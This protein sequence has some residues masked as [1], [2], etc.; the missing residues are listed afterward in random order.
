VPEFLYAREESSLRRALLAPLVLLEGPYR[1]GAWLHRLSY[2]RFPRRRVRLPAGVIA[3]GNL[4]VGGSGKTPLVAWLAA[5][6]RDRGRKVAI[7]SRGVGGQRSQ[8]VN[9]VSDGERVLLGPADVGD[10]PVLLAGLVPGVPVLAGRNRAALGYRAAALFGAEAV[11]LDD[12][13]Q[14]HRLERDVDLVCIDAELGLGNGHVLP[15]GPLRESPRG[16]KR[17]DA[18]IFTR[19]PEGF[20]L[21]AAAAKLPHAGDKPSFAASITP[22]Q[23]RMLTGEVRGLDTLQ[24][25][26]VGLL[27]AIA[28]PDRLRQTLA[29]LGAVLR[30][31]RILPDHRLYTR[32]DLASLDSELLWV[33][34][35]KDA[36]KI[37][38]DWLG[39]T[40]L[41][42]LEEELRELPPYGLVE[43]VLERLSASGGPR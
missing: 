10:E 26:P 13:F 20:A 24:A 3:V 25:E 15:R 9:V 31:E 17:A 22:R 41:A 36:V 23:L 39:D 34:T 2:Q 29:A 1:V 4:A 11:L 18:L 35:A 5:E 42:V 30:D 19:V 27:A 28:R 40:K 21:D 14:H 12:G 37:P 6:L 7:L 38:A 33:T 43:F 8:Q 16:L 32:A